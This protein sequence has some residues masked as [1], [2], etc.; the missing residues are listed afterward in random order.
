VAEA[1]VDQLEVVEVDERDAERALV[2][3]RERELLV[4]PILE[5]VAIGESRERVVVRPGAR[6]RP[7]SA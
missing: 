7:G 1:V 5:Q 2:A 6:A 3:M 4:Q